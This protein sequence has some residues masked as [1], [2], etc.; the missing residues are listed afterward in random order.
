MVLVNDGSVKDVIAGRYH[1]ESL[2]G[3]G[4]MGEVW[5]GFDA[6]L[7]RPVAVKLLRRPDQPILVERFKREGQMQ[8]SIEHE[9]VVR[10]FDIGESWFGGEDVLHLVMELLPGPTL[11]A[12]LEA[13]GAMEP[14]RAAILLAGV[15][16]ALRAA[17][18]S[19]IVHRDVK[20]ANLIFDHHRRLKISDFGIARPRERSGPRLTAAG[21]AMGSPAYMSPEQVGDRDATGA[22]DVYSLGCVLFETVAGRTPFVG[23]SGAALVAQHAAMPPP[24]ITDF[25]D[26]PAR[27][28]ALVARMLAKRPADRPS[29]DVVAQTLTA[30]AAEGDPPVPPRRPVPGSGER[31]A[32]VRPHRQ[33]TSDTKNSGAPSIA[34]FEA[35]IQLTV[36]AGNLD[37]DRARWFRDHLGRVVRKS[38][39]GDRAAVL[40]SLAYLQIAVDALPGSRTHGALSNLRRG[41]EVLRRD[42]G[43]DMEGRSV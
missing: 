1:L 14:K 28:D 11:S 36:D 4:G 26:V 41:F 40:L 10:V 35:A 43:V 16:G 27:L 2:L 33:P 30:E 34:A 42:L 32:V 39:R 18:S 20:P 21:V 7:R 25:A 6:D 3:R 24:R 15:A 8:A 5:R 23:E 13:D 22:S 17:H 29:L 31:D 12:S 19:G 38:K 37:P 9:L